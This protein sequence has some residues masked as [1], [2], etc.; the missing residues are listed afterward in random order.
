MGECE[1]QPSVA[2]EKSVDQERERRGGAH[3][4]K[5][6]RIGPATLKHL[7][8]DAFGFVPRGAVGVGGDREGGAAADAGL[9]LLGQGPVAPRKLAVEL[10]VAAQVFGADLRA[11][12]GLLIGSELSGSSKGETEPA[13]PLYKHELSDLWPIDPLLP[14]LGE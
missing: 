7:V 5:G 11:R 12:G 14:L 1:S 2:R 13:A 8:D 6:P 3:L 10:T 4:I 9:V